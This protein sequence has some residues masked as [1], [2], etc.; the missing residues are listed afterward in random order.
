MVY[1]YSKFVPFRAEILKPL[2]EAVKSNTFYW[3][4]DCDKA[5]EEIKNQLA[6]NTLLVHF[7]EN[8][9]LILHCDSTDFGIGAVLSHVIPDGNVRRIA[10]ASKT[11]SKHERNYSQIMKEALAIVFGVECFHQYLYLKH[12]TTITDHKPLTYIFN[13]SN[14]K[15][16]MMAASRMLRWRLFLANYDYDIKF[17]KSEENCVAE[18][19]SH[20]PLDLVSCY[21]S[22]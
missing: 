14:K 11:L 16:S 15:L 19:L 18:A 7:D 13:R 20:L 10:Y 12:C 2:Y 8:L 1:H 5:F 17:T 22:F 4:H 21:F 3:N 9:D 6:A